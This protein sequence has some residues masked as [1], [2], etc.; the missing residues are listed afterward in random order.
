MKQKLFPFNTH[1]QTEIMDGLSKRMKYSF[2]DS[3]FGGD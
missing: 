1:I 3:S 2:T